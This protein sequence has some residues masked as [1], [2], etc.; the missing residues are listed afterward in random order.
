MGLTAISFT[1]AAMSCMIALGLDAGKAAPAP[2]TSAAVSDVSRPRAAGMNPNGPASL[3]LI[4]ISNHVDVTD[5]D[6]VK[7]NVDALY[8]KATEGTT[9]LDVKLAEYAAAAKSKKIP[10]GFY[11]YFWPSSDTSLAVK[12]A[13]FFYSAIK[14]YGFEL[15]PALDVEETG[16]LP[17]TVIISGIRAFA[18]E[19]ERLSGCRVMIYCSQNFANRY[20]GDPSLGGYRLWIAHY[21]V[22]APGDTSTWD[23]YVVW[24]YGD[25]VTVPGIAGEVDG[26]AA[27]A[28]VFINEAS[29]GD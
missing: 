23:R 15:Y 1:V 20:L 9:Y 28:G 7:K 6:A 27:T 24:Q 22:G 17:D 8:M 18:D 4:D 26:D 3:R 25:R 13:R 11:H 2:D 29:M 16:G 5:W 12:Q 19:F 10:I 14:K 21:G